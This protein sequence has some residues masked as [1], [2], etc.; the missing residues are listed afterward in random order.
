MS[1]ST[2]NYICISVTVM[3]NVFYKTQTGMII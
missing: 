2:I 3:G 1:V